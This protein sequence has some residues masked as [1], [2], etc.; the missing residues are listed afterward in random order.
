M[1]REATKN[2][3]KADTGT[4]EP[5]A[6]ERV[7]GHQ[8]RRDKKLN[9]RN[10]R[11]KRSTVN[12]EKLEPGFTSLYCLFVR[13]HT[14]HTKT[15]IHTRTHARTHARTNTHLCISCRLCRVCP[16]I[17]AIHVEHQSLRFEL[18]R[19]PPVDLCTPSSVNQEGTRDEHCHSNAE[20]NCC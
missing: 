7:G 11:R 2:R 20:P 4:T 18:L 6:R 14:P 8:Q 9:S 5:C 1:L 13:A 10:L 15:H 19:L 16:R 17:A 3:I 12:Q